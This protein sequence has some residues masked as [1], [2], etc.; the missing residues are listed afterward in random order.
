LAIVETVKVIQRRFHEVDAAFAYYKG[1]E[2]RSPDS[3]PLAHR[4]ILTRL[5]Q[6][7]EAMLLYCERFRIVE[8][9]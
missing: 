5:G 7:A 8:R 6:F 3:W 2:D 4:R 1:E 9:L